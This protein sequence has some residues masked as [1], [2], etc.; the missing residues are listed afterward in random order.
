MDLDYVRKKVVISLDEYG[1]MVRDEIRSDDAV[2][3]EDWMVESVDQALSILSANGVYPYTNKSAA[4]ANAE[5]LGL[6]S[7]RYICVP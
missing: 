1:D 3:G 6:Q 4:R 7:Y 2:V 5:R